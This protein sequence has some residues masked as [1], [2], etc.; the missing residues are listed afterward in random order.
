MTWNPKGPS[1]T[2]DAIVWGILY[3]SGQF[4]A[5][6]TPYYDGSVV[7]YAGTPTGV[8]TAIRPTSTGI[9]RSRTT[10]RPSRWDLPRVVLTRWQTDE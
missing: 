2:H 1:V 8:K 5:S 3:V 7:T 9:R 10:G 4:D 6:G